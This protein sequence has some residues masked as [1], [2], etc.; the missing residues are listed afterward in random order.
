M[1]G[2]WEQKA[3]WVKAW[4]QVRC[5]KQCTAGTNHRQVSPITAKPATQNEE[6]A[7][8]TGQLITTVGDF[9]LTRTKSKVTLGWI[10]IWWVFS[11]FYPQL[12]VPYGLVRKW[13]LPRLRDTLASITQW[14][15]ITESSID[16]TH[17]KWAQGSWCCEI[18]RT[19]FIKGG[20]NYSANGGNVIHKNLE[21][22]GMDGF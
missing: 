17:R 1:T 10:I 20:S 6:E 9:L 7:K 13:T 14:M 22:C 5:I 3:M 12:S 18:R 15:L 2:W 19:V 21:T 16:G 11:A 4:K 8:G